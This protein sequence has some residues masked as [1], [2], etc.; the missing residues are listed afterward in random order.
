MEKEKRRVLIIDDDFD[1][2]QLTKDVLQFNGFETYDF[3]N[4]RLALDMFKQSP[5]SYDLVLMDIKMHEM[6]GYSLYKEIKQTNPNAKVI[7][8][9]GM[10]LD[11]NEFKKICPSFEEKQLI[12][13]PVRMSSLIKTV[14]E[15]MTSI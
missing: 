5:Q 7:V 9:T 12:Q 14:N 8:F 13:K 11:V 15:A 10:I 1:N 6:D 2:L 3:I 4:P